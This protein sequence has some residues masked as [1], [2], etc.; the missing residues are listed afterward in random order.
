[1]DEINPAVSAFVQEAREI[2]EGLEALLLDLESDSDAEQID[3]V[4]RTLHTVKGSGAMFGFGTLSRFTHHFEDAFDRVR[5][6]R[7]SVD[8]R[9][10]DLSLKAR[11]HMIALLDCGGDGPGATALEA[12]PGAVA[13]L[14]ALAE[15]T[16][17]ASVAPKGAAP[18]A[19]PEPAPSR[20]AG[21]R[22]T[23]RFRPEPDA[24]RNGM[25]P[26]LLIAELG[27]LGSVEVGA[28]IGALP[29]LAD[30]DPTLSHLGWTVTLDTDQPR[31]AIEAVFIFADDA[32]LEIT[33]EVTEPAPENPVRPVVGQAQPAAGEAS[34]KKPEKTGESVRVPAGKLDEIMDQ[35]GELVIAQARLS[36]MASHEP[37]LESVVEE[38]E[39]LVTG[40]RDATLSIRMLPIEVV[41]GKFRRVVRD[42]S[43]ELGKEVTLITEGGETE[44]DKTVIDRLSEPL[45]HMIRNS[46]DHGIESAGVRLAAGK[47]A[48][49][50]VRQEGGEVLI[51]IEDD[52]AGL[53]AEAIRA[54]AIERG[55]LTSEAQPGESELYQLI[56]APGFST[57]KELSSVSGRGVGMDAV[58]TTVD[59]LRGAVE[60][61]S[62]AGLGTRVTLRLP[63]TLAIIDGLLVRLG[64][65]VFVIPLASVEECVEL[66]AAERQRES[67]RTMLCIREHL[68]PFLDLDVVFG[69]D[70]STETRRRVVIVKADGQ[71]LGL[72]VDDILGQHQTVIKTLSQYHRDVEGFAGAT[73]LG[74]GSVALIIDVATLTRRALAERAERK[75]AA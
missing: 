34:R 50:T 44:I 54:K 35:L 14:A 43:A 70:P 22:W 20:T 11:D 1:M 28:D 66:D 71:R 3:A 7:L 75:P 48:R 53:D 60:V 6:G 32:E 39:R 42:L 16:G 33:G 74:D 13:L 65:A 37:E 4:F 27:G 25:R 69:R 23:I 19:T 56:F 18:Q 21:R 38:V 2:L 47:P 68:V 26:D 61:A 30:L 72:V 31:S 45:V 67:G 57:A 17:A 12:T 5:E 58:R 46:M 15:I 9:L 62:R 55:L 73:I 10:I 59:A 29:A 8:G 52:G 40:L 64:D 49:G 41:F 63:V 36:Q 24:L 51:A